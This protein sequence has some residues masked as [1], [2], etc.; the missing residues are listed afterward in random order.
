MS[1]LL[2]SI[3][4]PNDIKNIDRNDYKK[5][6][7]EIRRFLVNNVSKTG[8]H[9]ASNLG[10]VE[11]TMALHVVLDFPTDKIV[12]DVGH[13][14]YTHKL[15]T[16]RKDEFVNLRKYKGL[17]GFPK[18]NESECDVFDTGHSST[19]ISAAMGLAFADKLN[20][21]NS[22]VVA[23]IG[24][25]ALTGGMAYEALNNLSSLKRNFI[26]ILNDNNMSISENVG[27]MSEHL[28]KFRIGEKYNDLKL[29][30]EQSLNKIPMVGVKIA[31]G[32]KKTKDSLK[33]LFVPDGIFN[34]LGI[35]YIGPIDGHDTD[36]MIELFKHAKKI[37]HPVLIHLKTKKGYGYKFAMEDPAKFHGIDAF[38]KRTGI[39]RNNS[40]KDSY[41]TVFSKKIVEMANDDKEIVAITA[42][43]PDGTGL[44]NFKERYPD[45]FFDVGIAEEHA[46]TFAAGLAAG[47]KKPY[48]S[49]YSS[50]YQR[51]YDQILH[52]ICI[53]KLP[54]KIIIDR[55]GLVG[56]DGETHQG[57]FDIAFLSSIPNLTIISPMSAEELE[58]ALEYSKDFDAPIAIRFSRGDAFEYN[59]PDRTDSFELKSS[60]LTEG[61]NIAIIGIGSIVEEILESA[62]LL[63]E[64]GIYPTVVNAKVI[65]PIDTDMIEKLCGKHTHILL[66]EEGIKHGGYSEAVLNYIYQHNYKVKCDI[67]A[68]DDIFVKQ[69][70][71][72]HLRRKLG[73][74]RIS[75]MNKVIEML[76]D[77]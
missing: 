55:A 77:K 73:L 56:R 31:K 5:L 37:D 50:F 10:A 7:K 36:V 33:Q 61:N 53:Q 71:V 62:K 8:G 28:S 57:I 51:A 70:S 65:K 46:V 11:L 39:K 1:S 6:A 68:I 24:D 58:E 16:G 23:V 41:T 69:G 21:V 47:G 14:S 38:D 3:N 54:V 34:E 26:I 72:P 64:K 48:I 42:A 43:M 2:D 76:E 22:T 19:S 74:D 67:I 60:I 20:D 40:G 63:N 30:V 66:V 18:R 59:A 44:S 29:E 32:I 17:S 25:G 35:T 52:D 75:I 45:R 27:G 4:Q 13:Q 15:L 12:W 9:L 49:I